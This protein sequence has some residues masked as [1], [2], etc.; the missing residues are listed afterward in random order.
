M[1]DN[2]CLF[3]FSARTFWQ[4]N[5]GVTTII[6]ERGRIHNIVLNG[7]IA[8]FLQ[9]WLN[10]DIKS[11]C[12]KCFHDGPKWIPIIPAQHLPCFRLKKS[13]IAYFVVPH[14]AIFV[15]QLT[16]VLNA[17]SLWK[18]HVC[19]SSKVVKVCFITFSLQRTQ[20][21]D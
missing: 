20:Y 18:Q 14:V 7:C 17:F 19:R 10:E 6:L 5:E 15:S 21:S 1:S 8:A 13:K 12:F 16:S 4:N 2:A 11:S 3:S 9:N